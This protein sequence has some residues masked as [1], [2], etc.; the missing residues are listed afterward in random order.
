MGFFTTE[1]PARLG[2]DAVYW[3]NSAKIKAMGWK[4]QIDLR[5]GICRMVEWARAY[6]ELARLPDEFRI[7][8]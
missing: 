4:Q 2:E 8:P 3:L 1:A 7:Q 6:P 5:Q